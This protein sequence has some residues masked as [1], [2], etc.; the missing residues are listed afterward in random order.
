MWVHILENDILC[1]VRV[2]KKL[3]SKI[4]KRTFAELLT[5]YTIFSIHFTNKVHCFLYFVSVFRIDIN[6][7]SIFQH[8]SGRLWI[9][10]AYIIDIFEIRVEFIHDI[11]HPYT[12]IFF[13]DILFQL[14]GNFNDH[15]ISNILLLAP[16]P[17][18]SYDILKF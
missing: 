15:S 18:N 12:V 14:V 2:I 10:C 4:Y 17:S 16:S 8:L 3:F 6:R 7:Q 9:V 1:I 13:S 5:L 11:D